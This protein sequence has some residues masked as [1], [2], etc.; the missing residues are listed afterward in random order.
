MKN[1]QALAWLGR[2]LGIV[3]LVVCAVSGLARLAG[4]YTLNG[5]PVITSFQAGIA[6]LVAGCFF[7]LLALASRR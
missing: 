1:T 2:V 4:R 5:F 3:G 6:L 7:L